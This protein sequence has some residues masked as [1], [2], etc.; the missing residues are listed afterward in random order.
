MVAYELKNQA[1]ITARGG[2][3]EYSIQDRDNLQ[4]Q[5]LDNSGGSGGAVYAYIFAWVGTACTFVVLGEMGSMSVME[6]T[7]MLGSH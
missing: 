6:P 7:E 5:R 4:L 2:E 1:S 3:Q